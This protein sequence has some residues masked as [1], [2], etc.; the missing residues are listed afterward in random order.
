[1]NQKKAINRLN[2]LWKLGLEKIHFP[3]N[4]SGKKYHFKA[5]FNK[6]IDGFTI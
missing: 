2:V 5:Q 1:M 4:T 3:C 6:Q